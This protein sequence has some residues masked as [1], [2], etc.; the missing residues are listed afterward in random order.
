[1]SFFGHLHKKTKKARIS[2]IQ[3]VLAFS[4]FGEFV[5]P[6][7]I[8]ICRFF[9]SF[10]SAVSALF[11]QDGHA[12]GKDQKQHRIQ[13]H[14]DF[15]RQKAGHRRHGGAAQ[16]RNCHLGAHKGLG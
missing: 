11:R 8:L 16:I 14:G 4:I 12:Q 9:V 3:K 13:P 7:W 6:R 2:V 1:M 15:L 5:F 10:R